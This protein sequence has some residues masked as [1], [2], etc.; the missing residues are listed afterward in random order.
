MDGA[1]GLSAGRTA[2]GRGGA[3]RVIPGM[4][5]M[6]GAGVELSGLSPPCHLG[7]TWTCP[8][9]AAQRLMAHQSQHF[10]P[11][12]LADIFQRRARTSGS[13]AQGWRALF[14]AAKFYGI[15]PAARFPGTG[16]FAELPLSGKGRVPPDPAGI[17]VE[18]KPAHLQAAGISTADTKM[19]LSQ[20]IH[21]RRPQGA[22]DHTTART[23]GRVASALAG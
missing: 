12:G 4:H 18:I 3:C 14:L 11:V 8:A 1:A 22:E 9:A 15:G 2:C 21:H 5:S 6:G 13:D 10:R 16:L 20:P 19:Y 7:K 17:H 23:H